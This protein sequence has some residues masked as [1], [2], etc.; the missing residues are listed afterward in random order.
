LGVIEWGL[1]SQSS[2]FKGRLGPATSHTD[3][4]CTRPTV[5]GDDIKILENGEYVHPELLELTSKLRR[6]I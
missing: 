1:G 2:T 6:E 3:G 4:V 5:I